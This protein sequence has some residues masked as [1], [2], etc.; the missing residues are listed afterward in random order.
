MNLYNKLKNRD[1]ALDVNNNNAYYGYKF[2][3]GNEFA[4][5]DAVIIIKMN[6]IK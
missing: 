3:Y 5:T 4:N 1:L 6:N 2:G